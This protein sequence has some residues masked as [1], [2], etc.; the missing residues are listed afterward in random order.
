MEAGEDLR[1]VGEGVGRSQIQAGEL[2]EHGVVQVQPPSHLC[3]HNRGYSIDDPL[4]TN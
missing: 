3:K 1:D 4:P 2:A